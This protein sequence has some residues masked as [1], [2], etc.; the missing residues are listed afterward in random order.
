[1]KINSYKTCAYFAHLTEL[2]LIESK[3][4]LSDQKLSQVTLNYQKLSIKGVLN[5]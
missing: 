2:P 3:K 5:P 4:I 1:M